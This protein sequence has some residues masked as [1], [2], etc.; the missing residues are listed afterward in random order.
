MEENKDNIQVEKWVDIHE[1][2]EHFGLSKAKLEQLHSEGL[3]VLRIGKVR[4]Y[5]ITEVEAWLKER[6]SAAVQQK[7]G[8]SDS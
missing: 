3:P 2:V 1:L 5:K 8:G 7:K 4:R 6:S